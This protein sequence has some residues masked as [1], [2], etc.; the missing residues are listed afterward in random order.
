[1]QEDDWRSA[2]WIV[3]LVAVVVAGGYAVWRYR[4]RTAAVKL[5]G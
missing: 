3:T 4:S 1:V 2:G 5:R